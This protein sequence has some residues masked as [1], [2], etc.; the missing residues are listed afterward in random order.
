MTGHFIAAFLAL[1]WNVRYWNSL[2]IRPHESRRYFA[3]SVNL[4][5]C[6]YGFAPRFSL[7][8]ASGA[9]KAAFFCCAYDVVTDWRGFEARALKEFGKILRERVPAPETKLALDLLDAELT[10]HLTQDGLS[11]GPIALQFVCNLMG[12][13]NKTESLGVFLQIVDD[14]LDLEEDIKEK[15]VNCL[16]TE[17]RE[18][19]LRMFADYPADELSKQFPNGRVLLAVISRARTK[20]QALL[21]H[22]GIAPG[23][24]PAEQ[25]ERQPADRIQQEQNEQVACEVR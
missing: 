18:K 3:K 13:P 2:K 25:L 10:N 1:L 22:S 19:Y 12:F 5:L 7:S 20:A 6:Y 23:S 8:A 16:L 21:D 14:V 9:A 17:R 24:Q 11:R 4:A 15:Q